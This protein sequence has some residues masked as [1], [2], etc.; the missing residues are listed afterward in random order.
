VQ[1]EVEEQAEGVEGGEEEDGSAPAK[2]RR[3]GSDKETKGREGRA[4][5]TC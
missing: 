1:E 2:K 3:K 4:D 5:D